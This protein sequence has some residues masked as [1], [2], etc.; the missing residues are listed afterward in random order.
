MCACEVRS[1][2]IGLQVGTDP[3]PPTPTCRRAILCAVSDH[4]LDLNELS[5]HDYSAWCPL[6]MPGDLSYHGS[7]RPW[8]DVV[9]SDRPHCE[10]IAENNAY[11]L[12]LDA[13]GA[14]DLLPRLV[15]GME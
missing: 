13:F 10:I 4:E 15:F 7:V 1:M 9:V 2:S 3:S 12:I 5:G 8:I 6:F 14:S 11:G